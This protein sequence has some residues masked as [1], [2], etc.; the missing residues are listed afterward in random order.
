MIPAWFKVGARVW[1][2]GLG[3]ETEVVSIDP[4]NNSWAARDID[5]SRIYPLDEV[6]RFWRNRRSDENDVSKELWQPHK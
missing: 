1:F 5:G 2:M 3:Y 6:S 4:K